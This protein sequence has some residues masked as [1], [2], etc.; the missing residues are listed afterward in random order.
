MLGCKSPWTAAVATPSAVS[1]DDGR[2]GADDSREEWLQRLLGFCEGCLILTAS[3]TVQTARHF[4]EAFVSRFD[5]S[6]PYPTLRPS[7]QTSLV[8]TGNIFFLVCKIKDLAA[9]IAVTADLWQL[10]TSCSIS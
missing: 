1:R 8:G 9:F 7:L 2:F 4:K 5:I 10:E 3:G 6:F